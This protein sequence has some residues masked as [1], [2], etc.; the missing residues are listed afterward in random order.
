MY[1]LIAKLF[2]GLF[3]LNSSS[4]FAMMYCILLYLRRLVEFGPEH[5]G[6]WLLF[7]INLSE[8]LE[9]GSKDGSAHKCAEDL[10]IPAANLDS[11]ILCLLRGALCFSLFFLKNW[12]YF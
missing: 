4:Q 11:W 6:I 12:R 9:S 3:K 1:A 10:L 5:S 2:S 7:E 8:M